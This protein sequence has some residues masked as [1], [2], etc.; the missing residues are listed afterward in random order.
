MTPTTGTFSSTGTSMGSP[1][2]KTA[3]VDLRFSSLRRRIRAFGAVAPR[4]GPLRGGTAVVG[5]L[6]VAPKARTDAGFQFAG[7]RNPVA[8]PGIEPSPPRI[9]EKVTA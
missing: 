1:G 3:A 7:I 9:I 2:T 6:S 4:G 8:A 5:W